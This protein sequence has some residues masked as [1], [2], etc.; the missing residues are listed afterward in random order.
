MDHPPVAWLTLAYASVAE[1]FV[2]GT[3]PIYWGDTELRVDYANSK[4]PDSFTVARLRRTPYVSAEERAGQSQ[5]NEEL[6]KAIPV[7]AVR[8]G[9]WTQDRFSLEYQFLR[10][11]E[12]LNLHVRYD[13]RRRAIIIERVGR[14][15]QCTDKNG[16]PSGIASPTTSVIMLAIDMEHVWAN[17][18]ERMV[19]FRSCCAASFQHDHGRHL[20]T[21]YFDQTHAATSEF[22]SSTIGICFPDDFNF[23]TFLD[24]AGRIPHFPPVVEREFS[25]QSLGLFSEK[26][27]N[28][29][30]Q[31]YKS[32]PLAIALQCA[33]MINNSVVTPKE[34]ASLQPTITEMLA[35]GEAISVAAIQKFISSSRTLLKS[36]VQ[37]LR[38][39][40]ESA[41]LLA[42]TQRRSNAFYDEYAMCH[43]VYIT[44]T[45][46]ILEGPY[47]DQSNRVLRLYPDFHHHFMRVSFT[48]EGGQA[49]ALHKPHFSNVEWDDFIEN[50]VEK[51][52]VGG[53]QLAGRHWEWL[54]YSSSAL[55]EK[56]ML[57]MTP[58]KLPDGNNV[59][60]HRIRSDLGDFSKVIQQPAKYGA[61][62]AQVS[63]SSML[64]LNFSKSSFKAF[65]GTSATIIVQEHEIELIPDIERLD[66]GT[67]KKYC[68]T[69]GAGDM[70]PDMARE[71][72][73]YLG[74]RNRQ[75]RRVPPPS[76][77]QA[78]YELQSL[79][80]MISP[81]SN[82]FGGCKGVWMVNPQLEG[83]VIR[84]R[85]SQEKF[86]SRYR[87]FEVASTMLIF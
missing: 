49:R 6:G 75:R 33:Q 82:R 50:H 37:H 84:Y 69:D 15:T 63:F 51:L 20:R 68:F 28:F 48:D 47:P 42:I 14:V 54:G 77:F 9:V 18:K 57:F 30:Q 56:Q 79:S 7:T 62:I 24:C 58:F 53:F 67:G 87:G 1:E 43:Q 10:C 74:R 59:D 46:F 4:D 21:T 41:K 23:R 73:W 34:L 81:V 72:W 12:D 44:P 36:P 38:D 27:R 5:L 29:V 31:L 70:S 86:P 85:P 78:R 3:Y 80:M 39:A 60:S 13:V 66:E 71:I 17:A 64:F 11:T 65:S 35:D 55:K 52:L 16:L 22:T 40:F 2:N 61:R 83:T 25:V 76:A 19:L 26:Y 8:F 32:L 45:Q